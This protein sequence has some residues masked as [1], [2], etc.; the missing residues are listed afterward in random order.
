ME[1][2]EFR[3]LDE[4]IRYADGTFAN[5]KLLQYRCRSPVVDA[6]MAFCGWSDWNDWRTVY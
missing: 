3:W 1:F 6:S 5:T 2:I 4:T